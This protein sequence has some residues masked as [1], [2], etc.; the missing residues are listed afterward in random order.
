MSVYPLL[1]ETNLSG[2]D[3]QTEPRGLLS[4]SDVNSVNFLG[5]PF[6][7]LQEP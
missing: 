2:A 1:G 4:I 6:R 5:S 7:I 3:W